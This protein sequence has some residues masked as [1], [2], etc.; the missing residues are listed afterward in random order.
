MGQ[1]VSRSL[2]INL[3]SLPLASSRSAARTSPGTRVARRAWGRSIV[4]QA[5]TGTAEGGGRAGD[6]QADTLATHAANALRTGIAF[7][8]GPGSLALCAVDLDV[9]IPE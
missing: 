9:V 5:I 4:Q 2:D 7:V 8:Q 3:E 1:V 6:E